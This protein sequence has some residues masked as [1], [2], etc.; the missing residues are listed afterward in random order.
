MQS[1]THTV[2]G[3]VRGGVTMSVSIESVTKVLTSPRAAHSSAATGGEAKSEAAIT[4]PATGDGATLQNSRGTGS[5]KKDEEE[6][7]NEKLVGHSRTKTG[8]QYRVR[9]CGYSPSEYT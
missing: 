4:K 9:W 1:A 5:V 8:V 7:V 2:F 3:N 6:Y